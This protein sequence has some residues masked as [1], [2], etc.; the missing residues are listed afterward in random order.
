MMAGWMHDGGLNQGALDRGWM[1][2]C[3]RWSAP[4]WTRPL[5]PAS[6]ASA[7]PAVPGPLHRP[8]LLPL[9]LRSPPTSSGRPFGQGVSSSG[10]VRGESGPRPIRATLLIQQP[11]PKAQGKPELALPVPCDDATT[12]RHFPAHA[13]T[14]QKHTS[15]GPHSRLTACN[16]LPACSPLS[17]SPSQSQSRIRLLRL[18]DDD[19]LGGRGA[20]F[21]KLC[22]C[23]GWPLRLHLRT[24]TWCSVLCR[25]ARD[26]RCHE[27]STLHAARSRFSSNLAPAVRLAPRPTAFPASRRST[28]LSAVACLMDYSM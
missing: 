24:R 9:L 18:R 3:R 23:L 2:D 14:A 12:R 27:L 28:P 8:L 1:L 26:T 5:T 11:Q 17:Q 25:P 19:S 6:A 21:S 4:H 7:V 16:Q 22:C 13:D 20:I 15:T 10:G